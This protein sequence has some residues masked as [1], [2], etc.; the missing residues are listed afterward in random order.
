MSY[1]T[2]YTLLIKIKNYRQN[3][4]TLTKRTISPVLLFRP[5]VEKMKIKSCER[6]YS[7]KTFSHCDFTR[8]HCESSLREGRREIGS[9]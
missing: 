8:N 6:V 5:S 2:F 9:V 4:K 3:F 7:S 1:A